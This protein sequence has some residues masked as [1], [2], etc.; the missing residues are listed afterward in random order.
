ME[1]FYRYSLDIEKTREDLQKYSVDKGLSA[2]YS[3][4]L[5]TERDF[6]SS[7]YIGR[8]LKVLYMEKTSEN[9]PNRKNIS[10]S[11]KDLLTTEDFYIYNRSLN[12]YKSLLWSDGP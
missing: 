1:V 3:K 9:L 5:Y 6:G 8:I 2:F 7:L 12:R 10:F 11:I 4:G